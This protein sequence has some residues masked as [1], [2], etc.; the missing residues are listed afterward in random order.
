[1]HD[2]LATGRRFRV[3]NVIDDMKRGW[4]RAVPDTSISGRQVV[5]ELTD[6]IAA[7]QARHDRLGQWHRVDLERGLA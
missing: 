5:H 3:L 1:M 6:R 2:Q 7:R 4:L